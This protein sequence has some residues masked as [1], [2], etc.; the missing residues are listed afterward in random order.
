M[1]TNK[2]NK[3]PDSKPADAAKYQEFLIA[4]KNPRL[5]SSKFANLNRN[6][7]KYIFD[8]DTWLGDK[9]ATRDDKICLWTAFSRPEE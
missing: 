8:L 6:M 2:W 1:P 3:Y 7:P 4:F 5:Y 9:F